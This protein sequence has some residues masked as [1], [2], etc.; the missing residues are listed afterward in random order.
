MS[1]EKEGKLSIP[2]FDGDYEHWAMLMENLIR[3]KEWWSLIE[4]GITE[5]PRGTVINRQQ[6]S[7]L[8]EMK[9]KDLKVKNYLF[10][11]I[12]KVILKQILVKSSAKDL[13]DSMK[14]NFQGNERV[15]SAQ[16]QQMRREFEVLE[17]KNGESVKQ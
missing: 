8:A 12:D 17:M 6:R 9:L 13:W 7:E 14:V 1:V 4:D 15:Q 10:A 11:A 3:S 2:R 5:P 16:I